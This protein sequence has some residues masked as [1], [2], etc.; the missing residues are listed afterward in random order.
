[1]QLKNS[2]EAVIT[3]LST[4]FCVGI[5]TIAAVFATFSPLKFPYKISQDFHYC[6]FL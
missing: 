4:A 3:Q 5:Y 2:L 6:F 1:M